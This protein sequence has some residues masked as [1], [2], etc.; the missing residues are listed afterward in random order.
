MDAENHPGLDSPGIWRDLYAKRRIQTAEPIGLQQQFREVTL[1]ELKEQLSLGEIDHL[2]FEDESMIR[3]YLALQYNGFPKGQQRKIPTHGQHKGAKLFAAINYETGHVVHREEQRFTT[4]AFQRFLS[5]I[6]QKY[7]EG[8]SQSTSKSFDPIIGQ[9]QVR[10][11]MAHAFTAYG[12][13]SC[14]DCEIPA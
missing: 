10:N 3:A 8:C 4:A 9:F 13:P 2:L 6:L 11:D 14:S 5:D 7:P 12:A 1:P